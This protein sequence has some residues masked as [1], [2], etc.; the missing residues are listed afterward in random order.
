MTVLGGGAGDGAQD[1]MHDGEH[2]LSHQAT[3]QPTGHF[4]ASISLSVCLFI[5]QCQITLSLEQDNLDL[6]TSACQICDLEQGSVHLSH[7]QNEIISTYAM[8]L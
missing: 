6:S 8:G 4:S 1:S 5:W 2:V 3:I 7:L